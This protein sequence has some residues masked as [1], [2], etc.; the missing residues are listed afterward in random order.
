MRKSRR[1]DPRMFEGVRDVEETC[2]ATETLT[3]KGRH[4][5]GG[6][7]ASPCRCEPTGLTSA[8]PCSCATCARSRCFQG[9]EN[10]SGRQIVR[11]PSC[12]VENM[13]D[14]LANGGGNREES[15]TPRLLQ[16]GARFHAIGTLT[17]IKTLNPRFVAGSC[18]LSSGLACQRAPERCQV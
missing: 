15:C 12:R 4:R 13:R 8:R 17:R 9:V 10:T 1:S 18:P 5:V 6:A 2:F 11:W 14:R 16:L 7:R 3:R